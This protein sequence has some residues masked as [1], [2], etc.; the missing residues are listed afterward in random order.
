MGDK[1]KKQWNDFKTFLKNNNDY[2]IVID[3]A[4]VGYYKKG[5]PSNNSILKKPMH[6][7]YNQIHTMVQYFSSSS[8]KQKVLI[9]MHTRHFDTN[10]NIPSYAI[11]IIKS[12]I[13]NNQ[14]YKVPKGLN[15]DCFWLYASFLKQNKNIKLVT[16]DK[17]RD[18]YFQMCNERTFLLW[19]DIH[20]IKFS[21]GIE[22]EDN[23]KNRCVLL[24][25]PRIYTRKIQCIDVFVDNDTT[26][27]EEKKK[28]GIVIPMC[29]KGDEDGFLD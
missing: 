18:H 17:M 25:Y 11:P 10:N 26:K 29:K 16:N 14:L 23:K 3:G 2:N 27:E 24:D 20:Q 1:R 15:D 28:K 13:N 9:I 4:N 8:Q 12:W 22:E 19:K 21:F 7:D 5:I 6:V